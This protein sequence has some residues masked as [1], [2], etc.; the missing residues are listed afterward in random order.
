M[1]KHI[2]ADISKLNRGISHAD[3]IYPLYRPLD[4]GIPLNYAGIP[5]NTIAY[6]KCRCMGF[7]MSIKS[8]IAG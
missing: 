7:E 2:P 6:T 3:G 8:G 4:C 1:A 5:R